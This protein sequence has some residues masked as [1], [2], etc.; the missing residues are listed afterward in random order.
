MNFT[1]TKDKTLIIASLILIF[2]LI[3]LMLVKME[4][5]R[6]IRLA[7]RAERPTGARVEQI[8]PSA[9]EPEE[10]FSV[11]GEIVEIK[12]KILSLRV[13]TA[14]FNPFEEPEAEVKSVR[15]SDSTLFVR[16]ILDPLETVL[17]PQ[18]ASPYREIAIDFFELQKG[19]RIIAEAREN[20]KGKTEFEA[21]KIILVVIY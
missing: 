3:I 7:T 6:R 12:D 19:D 20:I 16:Q 11:S 13:D 17:N 1:T 5:N 9:R 4:T 10:L 21:D 8:F 2:F 18:S 14:W 15:I